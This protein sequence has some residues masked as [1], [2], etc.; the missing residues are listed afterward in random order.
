MRTYIHF[1]YIFRSYF[2]LKKIPNYDIYFQSG[3]YSYTTLIRGLSDIYRLE[4]WKVLCRG[5]T[6]TILRDAPFSALY[7]MIF[8]KLKNIPLLEGKY[9]KIKWSEKFVLNFFMCIKNVWNNI[10][11]TVASRTLFFYEAATFNKYP[12]TNFSH[13]LYACLI[14]LCVYKL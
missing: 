13:I 1:N 4:G 11:Q 5:W 6:P 12:P 7:F 8:I 3:Q 9:Y 14:W 10:Y 2:L